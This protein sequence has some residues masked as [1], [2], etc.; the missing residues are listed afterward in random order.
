MNECNDDFPKQILFKVFM[1]FI[2]N[3]AN[4]LTFVIALCIMNLFGV[5]E[6][7]SF[8]GGQQ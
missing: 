8:S 4:L 5:N 6:G 1:P 3:I 2:I 7:A